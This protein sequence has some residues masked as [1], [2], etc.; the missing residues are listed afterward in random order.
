MR[1]SGAPEYNP[2]E[3]SEEERE[4]EANQ[5]KVDAYAAPEVAKP[6]AAAPEPVA[7]S[8]AQ[9]QGFF[10]A[11]AA[12]PQQPA[13]PAATG[14]DLFSQNKATDLFGSSSGGFF[15]PSPTPAKVTTPQPTTP[16]SNTAAYDL[17]SSNSGNN[18][19]GP[20]P[21]QQAAPAAAPA[22]QPQ[23]NAFDFGFGAP[24]PPLQKPRPA[25]AETL[26]TLASVSG[27]SARCQPQQNAFDF[28]F[29]CFRPR[30]PAA[31]A[32]ELR[33]RN[34]RSA[35][36]PA[37][38]W[39]WRSCAA[40]CSAELRLRCPRTH[41]GPLRRLRLLTCLIALLFVNKHLLNTDLRGRRGLPVLSP[42]R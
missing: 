12:Q 40:A 34:A 17:F 6:V 27:C 25:S 7:Q 14:A 29:G 36:C 42:N 13:Q 18:L 37:E 31:R 24:A 32:A 23:Q 3:D 9:P 35:A 30:C 41:C 10:G 16:S 1:I 8:A 19:F 15:G 20:A 4:E 2:P 11:P 38:L 26:L 33:L 22:V 28:G 39:F 21:T 5:L